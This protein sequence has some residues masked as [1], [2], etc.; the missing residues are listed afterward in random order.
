MR[1]TAKSLF[2]VS[3]HVNN[4]KMSLAIRDKYDI[5]LKMLFALELKL[6]LNL[7]I[8]MKK[9][10]PTLNTTEIT[11]LHQEIAVFIGESS[12]YQKPSAEQLEKFQ[13][14]LECAKTHIETYKEDHNAYKHLIEFY[15]EGSQVLSHLNKGVFTQDQMMIFDNYAG[16]KV[17][18]VTYL[19]KSMSLL[20]RNITSPKTIPTP[21]ISAAVRQKVTHPSVLYVQQSL[22]KLLTP[23][24][25]FVLETSERLEDGLVLVLKG[26]IQDTH[27]NWFNTRLQGN[28]RWAFFPAENK[29]GHSIIKIFLVEC[30]LQLEKMASEMTNVI[31][32]GV[33]AQGLPVSNETKE[34]CRKKVLLR[35]FEVYPDRESLRRVNEP[36]TD[37]II[38]TIGSQICFKLE[39]EVN[40][41]NSSSGPK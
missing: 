31:I 16:K 38:L 23:K 5:M 10:Q 12:F 40:K 26:C 28:Y 7:E 14:F 9:P 22:A 15:N 34:E 35:L 24:F 37:E 32:E 21:E 41:G 29:A 18:I 19:P 13:R 8:K 1:K 25:P 30:Q 17:P 4:R 36:K 2:C 11:Q 33:K 39:A 20:L 3:K 6:N 27:Q